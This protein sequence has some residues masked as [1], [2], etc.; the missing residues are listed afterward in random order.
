MLWG[1]AGVLLSL[2]LFWPDLILFPQPFPC[3]PRLCQ[4]QHL[5]VSD[6]AV[7]HKLPGEPAGPCWCCSGVRGW[8]I[9][10]NFYQVLLTPTPDLP[11]A[12]GGIKFHFCVLSGKG[13]M[14]SKEQ[15]NQRSH[16]IWG[17]RTWIWGGLCPCLR[18]EAHSFFQP[19][20]LEV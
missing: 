12:K 9:F 13:E 3:S 10:C 15:K 5:W 8:S 14:F 20:K 11:S 6:L 1:L 17:K 2:S 16:L 4:W 19:P 7:L 18:Y